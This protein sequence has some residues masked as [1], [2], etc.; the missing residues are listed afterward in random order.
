MTNATITRRQP[1]SERFAPRE[2]RWTVELLYQVADQWVFGE[3]LLIELVRGKVIQHSGQT[4][5]HAYLTEH[6]TRILRAV[7]EPGLMI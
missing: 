5:L 4:P 2:F 1:T 7:L 3:P 6:M